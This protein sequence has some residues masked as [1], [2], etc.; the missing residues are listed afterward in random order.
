MARGIQRDRKVKA[1]GGWNMSLAQMISLWATFSKMN[2]AIRKLL[3]IA[4]FPVFWL[5][6]KTDVKPVDFDGGETGLS[7]SA[8]K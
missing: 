5:L 7:V 1:L 4:L 2:A 6:V 8:R 3:S